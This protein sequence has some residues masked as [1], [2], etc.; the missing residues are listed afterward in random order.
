MIFETELAYFESI[1]EEL[2]RHNSGQFA[3]IRG[4]RLLGTYTTDH[5]AF[6]AGV[7]EFRLEPFLLKPI[8][9]EEQVVQYPALAVGAIHAH[10]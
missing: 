3:V 4:D 9:E 7:R 5:E 6:E 1:K 8:V 10:P 2:L